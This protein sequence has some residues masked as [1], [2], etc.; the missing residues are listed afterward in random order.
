M[1]L[2]PDRRV[3]MPG[4]V[5]DNVVQESVRRI[6]LFHG[7]RGTVR[8]GETA[9]EGGIVVVVGPGSAAGTDEPQLTRALSLLLQRS[10]S[11]RRIQAA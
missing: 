4:P 10:V 6:L 5:D 2:R 11:I 7:V 8:L 9:D 3:S 1:E